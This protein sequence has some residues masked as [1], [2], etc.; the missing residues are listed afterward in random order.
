MNAKA[1]SKSGKPQT[2]GKSPSGTSSEMVSEN[3]KAHHRF[4]ILEQIECGVALQGSEVKSLR[5]HKL[6]LEESY[7]RV[8]KGEL[9]LVGADIAEYKQAT[10]WNHAPK[11]P[12]KLLVHKRQ[13]DKLSARARENGLTLVPLKVYFNERGIVKVLLGVGR[14]KK[15]YDKRQSL[16]TAEAKRSIARATRRGK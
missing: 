2:G 16:K 5:D 3:R 10:L 12:R 9:W 6:S 1:K 14:G 13:L 7:A 15:L 11:R 8:I 4:E